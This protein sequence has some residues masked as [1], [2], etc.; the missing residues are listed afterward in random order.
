M[1]KKIEP[2]TSEAAE[3]AIGDLS[4]HAA[5][6]A[7]L[8]IVE[9]ASLVRQ[10]TAR[11]GAI[12]QR[13]VEV[14][15]GGKRLDP[16]SVWVAEEWVSGP[17]AFIEWC[18]AATETLDA[19]A[20]GEAPNL[21]GV[22]RTERGTAAVRVFPANVWD[23]LLLNG[24]TA[25]VYMQDGV[26]PENLYEHMASFY[27]DPD[28]PGVVA[29]VL[30]AGNITSIAPLDATYRLFVMG[31]VVMLKMNPVNEW[32]GPVFEELFAPLIERGWMR[33]A[34][35]GAEVGKLLTTHELVDE[36]HLTGSDHTYD[37]IVFGTG[38]EGAARKARNEP[39]NQ[40]P[41]T[42][43]LGGV[44]PTIVLPGGAWTKADLRF[45]AENLVTQKLHNSG[46]NCV[47]AQVLVVPAQ[48]ELTDVLL[49]EIEAVMRELPPRVA[50]YPGAGERQADAVARH[51]DH[52]VVPNGDVPR[53][54]LR[55][56]SPDDDHFAFREEFFG[57]VLAV[58]RLPGA[59]PAQF[60]SN[61]VRFANE[62]LRGTLGATI[63]VHP[64]VKRQLG[65]AFDKG[66]EDLRYGAIGVN[67]WNAAAYL[68]PR[69]AWGAYP[70]HEPVDIQSGVGTVHNAYMFDKPA[71]TVVTG[72]F[73]PMPRAWRSG[74]L[75]I[76]PKPLWFVTN[77]TANITARKVTHFA[78]NPS[79]AALPGIFAAAL[80]G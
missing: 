33:L 18:Q 66:I 61:A 27:S 62:R 29:V 36:I 53:T 52:V 3:S 51:T 35:G 76:A 20:R 71:K 22:R 37:A 2:T 41:V 25:E 31:H 73:A 46:H 77:K 47:A 44:G 39:L 58:T 10:L 43:E 50:W 60:W 40:K 23:S 13:W 79:L 69:G 34:Y 24:V 17:W 68:L 16:D 74:E 64:T 75:H 30:G 67:I 11:A 70:G 65:A 72:P 21:P 56:V 57:V 4:K 80:R 28:P 1:T 14:A 45:H 5:G 42:A 48:W 19:L 9:K 49:D 6:W 7:K 15:A 26:T 32:M 63:T 78:A 8:P 59:T 55:D 38:T 54:I 12:A